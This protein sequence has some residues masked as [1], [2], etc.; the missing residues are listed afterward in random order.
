MPTTLER[1]RKR[2]RVMPSGCWEFQ[3]SRTV[4]GSYGQIRIGDSAQRVHRVMWE[5]VCGPIPAGLCVLHTCDNPPC[6]NP[7]HLFLGTRTENAADKVAK[8]R[9]AKGEALSKLTLEQ[10]ETIRTDTRTQ[11][12]VAADYGVVGSTI[13]RIRNG[14]RWRES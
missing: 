2:L 9:Q 7:A 1:I 10:V 8:D 14:T 13:C 6:A 11:R 5:E 3:G 12:E 4:S